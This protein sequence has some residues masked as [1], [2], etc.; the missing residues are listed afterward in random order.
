MSTPFPYYLNAPSLSTATGVF[1][2]AQLSICAPNG[3]YSDGLVVRQQ[4][5]CVLSPAEPCPGC[6]LLCNFAPMTITAGPKAV[7]Q[8][9]VNTGT[10][11]T[12]IGAIIIKFT[13]RTLPHGFQAAFNGNLYNKLSSP[14]YG[15]LASSDPLVP[16]YVG[17][18]TSPCAALIGST[19]FL[20]VPIYIYGGGSFNDSGNTTTVTTLPAQVALTAADP[21]E[22]IMVVPKTFATPNIVDIE[23]TMPCSGGN[24]DFDIEV[25][26]PAQ[27]PI[28]TG[29]LR[30][31]T[32]I[33]ACAY[34]GPT[35]EYFVAYVNGG[36]GVLGL[37]DWMFSDPNGQFPLA[38]GWYASVNVPAPNN[39]FEIQNGLVVGF[40]A[41]I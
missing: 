21:G 35:I 32:K 8:L 25:L 20:N 33:E 17:P 29:G 4:V 39:L 15:Y 6:G 27:L 30:G 11:A 10:E 14:T 40:D 13:P 7:Y 18:N 16:T 3:Y 34:S 5:D 38:D 28:V 22:C 37:Y 41:C 12:D 1:L 24:A 23:I 36:A 31:D 2:D 9:P 19:S 26:C